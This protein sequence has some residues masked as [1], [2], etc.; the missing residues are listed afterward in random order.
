[1]GVCMQI[2]VYILL[3]AVHL[4]KRYTTR[5]KSNFSKPRMHVIAFFGDTYYINH[6]LCTVRI[7][8]KALA[9]GP[10]ALNRIRT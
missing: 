6:A 9:L 5:Q 8:Y 2:R 1:M 3:L 10:R 4:S 7:L